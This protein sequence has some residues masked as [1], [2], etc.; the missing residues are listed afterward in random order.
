MQKYLLLLECSISSTEL[1][2][3]TSIAISVDV[4]TV[5]LATQ[6]RPFSTDWAFVTSNPV[7]VCAVA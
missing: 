5:P 6:F 7:N 2:A 1:P 4:G 3:A